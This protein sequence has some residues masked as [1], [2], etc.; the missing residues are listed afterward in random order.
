MSFTAE[1]TV[2]ID[3]GD[4]HEWILSSGRVPSSFVDNVYVWGPPRTNKGN[5]TLEIDFAMDG[6]GNCPSTWAEEP[7][8]LKQWDNLNKNTPSQ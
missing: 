3:L 7:N 2:E 1:G 6:N 4:L 5:G 8:A